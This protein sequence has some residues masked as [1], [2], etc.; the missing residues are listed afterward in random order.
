MNTLIPINNVNVSFKVNGDKIFAN[1]LQIA[2]VF[3]KT[4]QMF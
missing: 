2:E 1:S 3:E 4:T